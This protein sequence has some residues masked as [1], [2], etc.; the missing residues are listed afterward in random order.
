M[1]VVG[2]DRSPEAVDRANARAADRGS[3]NARFVVGDI[4][5]PA[6]GGPFDTVV[7]RLVLMYV[8]DPVAVIRAQLP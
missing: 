2:I 8:P 3:A 5:D 6:P 7:G 1:T 4:S